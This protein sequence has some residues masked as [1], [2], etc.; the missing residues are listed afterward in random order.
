[1]TIPE[2]EQAIAQAEKIHAYISIAQGPG[3]TLGTVTISKKEALHL[4]HM[5]PNHKLINAHW[6]PFFPTHLHVG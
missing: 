5:M 2:Y 1:M 6:N 3:R 4:I